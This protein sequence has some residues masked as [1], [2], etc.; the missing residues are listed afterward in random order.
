MRES[1]INFA[2]CLSSAQQSGDSS[3][4]QS[5][6]RLDFS[7]PI[8]SE[9]DFNPSNI[10]PKAKQMFPGSKRTSYE[11]FA[12]SFQSKRQKLSGASPA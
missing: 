11:S 6:K 2:S 3:E 5:Q 12:D 9:D 10:T 8:K 7:T 1:G 4:S